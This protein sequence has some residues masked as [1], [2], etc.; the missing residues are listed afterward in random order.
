MEIRDI[1]LFLEAGEP[2][3][4]RLDLAVSLAERSGAALTGLCAWRMPALEPVDTYAV[5]LKA[6]DDVLLREEAAAG[7]RIAPIKAA[8]SERTSRRN[9]E[10]LWTLAA[11]Y[12][13]PQDLAL[14]ARCF[15]LA[16]LRRPLVHDHEGRRLAERVALRSG[17]ACLIVPEQPLRSASLD[18]VV[19][20]W[21]GGREAKRAMDAA[22]DLLK[23]AANVRLVVVDGEGAECPPPLAP[24]VVLRH[25]ARH[26]IAADLRRVHAAHEDAGP[27]LLEHC[28]EFDADLLV[29][30]AYGHSVAEEVVF[31]GATRA[32]LADAALPVMMAH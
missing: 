13:S 22:M 9:V 10:S 16:I 31:G 7:E 30:G 20:A 2:C 14:H 8:F 28:A 15:D 24:E 3:A 32:V 1:L 5:G 29:M 23:A 19:L 4:A 18:R 26:G 25:L 11:L 27:A 12:E 6:M 21:D 17:T